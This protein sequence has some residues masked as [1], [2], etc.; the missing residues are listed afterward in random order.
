MSTQREITL[1][2]DKDLGAMVE[3][4]IAEAT[5]KPGVGMAR[6]ELSLARIQD[7]ATGLKVALAQEQAAMGEM[8]EA[9]E[10]QRDKAKWAWQFI[11]A[12]ASDGHNRAH[13]GRAIALAKCTESPCPGWREDLGSYRDIIDASEAA[14]AKYAA[15]HV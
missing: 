10:G 3:A 4:I 15:R 1:R 8:A 5:H 2:P 9:L 6:R 13:D 12:V 11:A 7:Y 14:L